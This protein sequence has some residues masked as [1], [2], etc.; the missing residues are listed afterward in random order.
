MCLP[1][2]YR[3]MKTCNKCNQEFPSTIWIEGKRKFLNKRSYCLV[4]SPL[5]NRRG[6]DLR[7]AKRPNSKSCPICSRWFKYTK[8]NICSSCRTSL[9]RYQQRKQAYEILGNQCKKCGENDADVLTCH[10]RNPDEKSFELSTAW[11]SIAW[12]LIEREL[13]KC[14]LL[15][16]NCHLKIHANENQC[17]FKLIEQYLNRP[18]GEI[19]ST[20][21]T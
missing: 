20:Q 15:C 5:H 11:G 9:L 2:Y 10:H 16:A 4:C 17:R 21:Q 18:H 1:Y 6:Y 3:F 13:S 7:K 19:G 12:E 8:N 14:D